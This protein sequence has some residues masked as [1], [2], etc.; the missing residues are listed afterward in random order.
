MK[1]PVSRTPVGWVALFAFM[2]IAFPWRA[3]GNAW[4]ERYQFSQ[5]TNLFLDHS[6]VGFSPSRIKIEGD[7]FSPARLLFEAQVAP[8]LFFPQAHFG[9]AGSRSGEYIV[10]LVFTPRLRFRMLNEQSSPII[11][12]SFMP[13]LTLQLLHMRQLEGEGIRRGVALGAHLIVGH[14]SNGQSGCFFQNQVGSGP[15]CDAEGRLPLNEE[16]GSFSTNY[17]RGELHG[18]F[19]FGVSDNLKAAWVAGGGVWTEVNSKGGPGGISN[20]QRRVYGRGHNG[21]EVTVERL[22]SGH[23]ARSSFEA[24]FPYGETPNQRPTI[25]V[26]AAIIPRWGGGFGLFARHV[27]GQDYYNILFL[28]RVN[29]WLLGIVFELGP[30][31]TTPEGSPAALH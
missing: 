24:S 21:L 31:I 8:N 17:I 11:P 30:G 7:P 15:S 27:S 1:Y 6:Y 29:L 18:R 20:D 25:S 13:K 9:E 4:A 16:A 10:S 23:R 14:Y 3:S 19:V 12:P 28:E 2:L 5:P 26:E 22:W